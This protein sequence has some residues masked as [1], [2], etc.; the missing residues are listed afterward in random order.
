MIHSLNAVLLLH[1]EIDAEMQALETAP[2]SSAFYIG[3]LGLFGPTR[4]ATSLVLCVLSD[5]AASRL[6][7]FGWLCREKK[8]LTTA[9]SR[10]SCRDGAFTFGTSRC[11]T[12]AIFRRRVSDSP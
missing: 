7:A 9:P 12:R 6:V 4:D 3:A 10:S 11:P 1:H 5:V 2:L 8:S